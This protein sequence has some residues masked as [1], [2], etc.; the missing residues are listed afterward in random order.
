[1]EKK[2]GIQLS[3]AFGAV[4]TLVL[5]AVLVIV[6]IVIFVSL[7]TSFS[8]TTSVTVTNETG[9]W[10]NTTSYTLNGAGNCSF[11]SPVITEARNATAN[12][13]ILVG[14]YTT[15]TAGIVS[16]R[17][18]SRV[19]T[20][21][22]TAYINVTGYTVAGAST[23]GANTF[24]LTNLTNL[25]DASSIGLANATISSAGVI[26]NATVTNWLEN[27]SVDYTYAA[28]AE[29]NDVQF[30]YTYTWGS[31]A[32]DASEDITSEFGNYTSLIGLV[33]TIIFLGLVIG[34]LVAAF[35]FGG[36]R[37]V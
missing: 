7:A 32:C 20:A 27:V 37:E 35:A 10:I 23:T 33:G 16:T 15:S 12:T 3:Q 29:F 30:D 36:R 6:A 13:A 4:L 31:E 1:M 19:V 14:N 9:G 2:K 26:T 18:T 8:G 25:T 5:V 34:V 17:N 24:V 28:P 21:E 11:A 22:A